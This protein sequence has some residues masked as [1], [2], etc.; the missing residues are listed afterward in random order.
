MAA[1]NR[2]DWGAGGIASWGRIGLE[3]AGAMGVIGGPGEELSGLISQYCGSLGCLLGSLGSLR[4]GE[5]NNRLSRWARLR[6]HS[7]SHSLRTHAQTNTHTLFFPA[8]S[9]STILLP[10]GVP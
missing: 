2:G 4:M 7:H 1:T 10:V 3:V 5:V 9:T 6:R 8:F